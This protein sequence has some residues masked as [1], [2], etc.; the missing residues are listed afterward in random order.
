MSLL[1]PL[2]LTECEGC[3]RELLRQAR[4]DGTTA[5]DPIEVARAL[6]LSIVPA[7]RGPLCG[8]YDLEAGIIYCH[9][10][11]GPDERRDEIAHELAHVALELGDYALPHDEA[12]VDDV[13]RALLMPRRELW[14]LL[15]TLRVDGPELRQTYAR[16]LPRER[17]LRLRQV[18]ALMGVRLLPR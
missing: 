4:L 9:A 7:L 5:P 11:R 2:E 13:K 14:R 16:T 15:Q 12:S 3:A 17:D 8:W 18:Y 10:G 6:G 1:P